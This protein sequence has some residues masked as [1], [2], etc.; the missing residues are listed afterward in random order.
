MDKCE[1]DINDTKTFCWKDYI[2]IIG[3]DNECWL[4]YP[5]SEKIGN[6]DINKH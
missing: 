3:K 2:Y 5:K 6:I 1:I 4:N